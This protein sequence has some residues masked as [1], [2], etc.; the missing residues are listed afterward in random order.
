MVSDQCKVPQ[1]AYVQYVAASPYAAAAP[2]MDSMGS[3]G[4]PSAALVV[5]ESG[6]AGGRAELP[7]NRPYW[8]GPPLSAPR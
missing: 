7:A 6:R 5:A 2:P 3:A 8:A 4:A 1:E